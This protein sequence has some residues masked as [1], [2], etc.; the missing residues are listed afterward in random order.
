LTY[1]REQVAA[2]VAKYPGR[3]GNEGGSFYAGERSL[4]TIARALDMKAPTAKRTLQRLVD[5]GK[6]GRDYSGSHYCAARTRAQ[7]E[8]MRAKDAEA[9]AT[10]ARLLET[11]ASAGVKT[12]SPRYGSEN[13]I[14]ITFGELARLLE[15]VKSA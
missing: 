1:L 8:T 2:D 13:A 5:A 7:L 6:I 3:A 12:S 4:H 11:I 15:H 14:T 9:E 10:K